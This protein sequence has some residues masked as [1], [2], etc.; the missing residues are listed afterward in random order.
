MNMYGKI[1]IIIRCSGSYD[2][3]AE[4][5][6]GYVC[7]EEEAKTKCKEL[8]S[9]IPTNPYSTNERL[10]R[11]EEA[12]MDWDEIESEWWT[13]QHEQCPYYDETSQPFI[14]D[15]TAYYAWEDKKKE[16]CIALRNE[17]FEQNHSDLTTPQELQQWLDWEDI[18]DMDVHYK[19][20]AIERL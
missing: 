9:Q 10:V 5:A 19:Y 1:Y 3:Y 12:F 6:V 15:A 18:Q 8:T 2:D 20:K 4:I 13:K 7:T 17:W 14:K 11:V 16:E